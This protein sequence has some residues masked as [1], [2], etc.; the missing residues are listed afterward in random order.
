MLA[1]GYSWRLFFYVE[2]AFAAALLVLAFLFVEES[3]YHRPEPKQSPPAT[4]AEADEKIQQPVEFENVTPAVIPERKSFLATLKLWS[5]V[6][7]KTPF[8][9]TMFRSFTYFFVPAVF[10]VISSF[11]MD[12]IWSVYFAFY[13]NNCSKEFTSAWVL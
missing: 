13:A 1:G 7:N 10:W 5:H 11:G 4:V 2:I 6:D 8:F 12:C 3:M 9:T